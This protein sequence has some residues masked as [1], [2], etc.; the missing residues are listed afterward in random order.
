MLI[1]NTG[2]AAPASGY[3]GEGAAVSVV[4]P[5]ARAAPGVAPPVNTQTQPTVEQLKKAVD[6]INQV[7]QQSNPSVEFSI[8]QSTK[9]TVI[10]VVDSQSGQLITQ[11]PSKEALAISR[12]IG[13]GLHGA[14]IKQDA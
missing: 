11:F 4:S 5:G 12:M 13:Q 3:T 1:Q 2:S 6:S 9:Q 8:D 14:L 10:K 7:V